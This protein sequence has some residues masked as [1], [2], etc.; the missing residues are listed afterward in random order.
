MKRFLSLALMVLLVFSMLA[1][2]AMAASGYTVKTTASV[3]LR[4][5]PGL[6]YGKI[7]SVSSGKSFTYQGISQF[8][9]RGIAWHK[10]SYNGGTA[11]ISWKYS[12][13]QY[14]GNSIDESNCVQ[15][16]A[17]VNLRAGAGTNYAKLTSVSKEKRLV[18]LGESQNDSRGVRWYKVSCSKG[19]A[20]VSSRYSKLV[21]PG[22][23]ISSST[24]VTT[25]SV[26][27]RKGPGLHYATI[28]SVSEG[29]S[30]SYLETQTDSRGV[31]WFKVSYNG[32]TAW[33]SSKY[34]RIS[35]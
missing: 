8:D 15:A 18:Y 16:T 5:G 7:T 21:A 32:G 28:T 2:P 34:S 4:K 29:R 9:S 12:N 31:K 30:F 20:W 17:S 10:I 26:N 13:L 6:D 27:L 14:N 19:I 33:I 35:G 11:W 25:A 3:N 22:S 24:V 23:S 1:T